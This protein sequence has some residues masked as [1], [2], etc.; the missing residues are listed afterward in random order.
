MT[1]FLVPGRNPFGL[2]LCIEEVDALAAECCDEIIGE[3]A[4]EDKP[5]GCTNSHFPI[6]T[7][8]WSTSAGRPGFDDQGEPVFP[9]PRANSCFSISWTGILTRS[10]CS[11]R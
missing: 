11:S 9:D 4:P 8:R 6:R 5:W 10:L 3:H 2:Y 1:S 7:R